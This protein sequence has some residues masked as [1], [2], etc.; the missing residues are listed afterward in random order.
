MRAEEITSSDLLSYTNQLRCA[1]V[2]MKALC[3]DVEKVYLKDPYGK[4]VKLV[5]DHKKSEMQMME[6]Y[7]DY[8]VMLEDEAER[9]GQ[10]KDKEYTEVE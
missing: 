6:E 4:L 8:I 10:E 7:E 3:P 5:N 9:L 1:I 2:F